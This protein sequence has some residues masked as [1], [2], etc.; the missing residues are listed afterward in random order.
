MEGTSEHAI[1]ATNA[2]L[3]IVNHR[4]FWQLGNTTNQTGCRTAG[5]QAMH[6]T[7]LGKP[8]GVDFQDGR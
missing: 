7:L 4:A 1:P 8:T 6:T 3:W 2:F 5:F